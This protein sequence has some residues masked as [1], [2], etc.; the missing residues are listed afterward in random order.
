MSIHF[1]AIKWLLQPVDLYRPSGFERP[2]MPFR[3]SQ[4]VSQS[5]PHLTR[6]FQFI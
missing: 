6:I 4:S 1:V 3:V 5:V 2:D